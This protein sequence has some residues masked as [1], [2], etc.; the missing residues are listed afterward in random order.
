MCGGPARSVP[1][2]SLVNGSLSPYEPRLVDSVN[3]L[4]PSGSYC[5]S[6]LSSS[7]ECLIMGLY[8]RFQKLLS[9]TSLMTVELS[10]NL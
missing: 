9:E 6:S 1:A 4:V 8:I 7:G 3:V 5:P 2:S 10:T